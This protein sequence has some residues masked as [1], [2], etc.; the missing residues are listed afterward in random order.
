MIHI[1]GLM[2]IKDGVQIFSQPTIKGGMGKLE[3]D[4]ILD[5]HS[6]EYTWQTFHILTTFR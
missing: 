1:S 4:L 2:M 3:I 6:I 5:T